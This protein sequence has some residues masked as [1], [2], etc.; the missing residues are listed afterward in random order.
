MRSP[1]KVIPPGGQNVHFSRKMLI[2]VQFFPEIAVFVVISGSPAIER[3]IK[4]FQENVQISDF[5][6]KTKNS[7]PEFYFALARFFQI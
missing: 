1:I 2:F 5:C 3:I 6:T 4:A 7:F